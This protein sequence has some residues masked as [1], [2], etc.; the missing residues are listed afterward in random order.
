MRA[1]IFLDG[2]YILTHLKQYNL[3]PDYRGIVDFLMK[4]LR[5]NVPLDLLRCYF[6]YCP[7][8][9]SDVPTSGEIRRMAEHD[10]LMKELMSLDRWAVR[11]GKLQR[12]W[13]GHREYFEQKRVD[14]LLSVDMVRHS[15]AGHIQHAIVVAGDSD[16]IPA[17]ELTK[18]SGATVSLW[19]GQDD[20]VH[21][22]LLNQSDIIHR[23][24]WRKFPSRKTGGGT[25]IISTVQRKV[26]AII[27]PEPQT[28]AAQP[29]VHESSTPS[30]HDENTQSASSLTAS[31]RPRRRRGGR[32]RRKKAAPGA[33]ET[34]ATE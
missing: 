8:W 24:D 13:E 32:G 26:A 31:G 16:F 33:P 4:P 6:Y 30:A 22:D 11:L 27:H 20:T 14:V 10:L 5:K 23:F 1:A 2:A 9:M 19:C 3:A 28:T 21:Q 17:I 34:P 25:G 29:A 7:P 18:E 12:R 15:A